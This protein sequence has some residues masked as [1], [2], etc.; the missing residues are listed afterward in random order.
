MF[1]VM[2]IVAESVLLM[3]VALAICSIMVLLKPKS[4]KMFRV[5]S[6][7]DFFSLLFSSVHIIRPHTNSGQKYNGI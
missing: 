1:I 5:V 4:E 3:W 2:R 6:M 7:I